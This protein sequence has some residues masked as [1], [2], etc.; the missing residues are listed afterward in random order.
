[1]YCLSCCWGIWLKIPKYFYF[2]CQGNTI[3]IWTLPENTWTHSVNK[4]FTV[5]AS[6]SLS[7]TSLID[8]SVFIC[9]DMLSYC[10]SPFLIWNKDLNQL[11]SDIISSNSEIFRIS[12]STVEL[13]RDA[14]TEKSAVPKYLH[15]KSWTVGF[16]ILRISGVLFMDLGFQLIW[17]HE[18][19]KYC[20]LIYEYIYCCR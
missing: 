18:I 10:V 15:K 16:G 4:Q 14:C 9:I 19:M 7:H 12:N 8:W 1:M 3:D 2:W 6:L 11:K 20:F 13:F 5:K 17:I